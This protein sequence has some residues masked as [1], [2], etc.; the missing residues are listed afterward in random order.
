MTCTS[1]EIL[2]L[3]VE[4]D[5]LVGE[6]I[7]ASVDEAGYRAIGPARSLAEAKAAIADHALTAALL[8]IHLAGD[9]RSFELAEI[10]A[11]IRVPFAFLSAYSGALTPLRFRDAPHLMKPFTG[12]ALAELL[13]R[14]VAAPQ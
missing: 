12:E 13:R 2:I 9:D 10:L 7:R 6:H 8:D 5:P 14:L 3:I 4:D 1:S 11:A